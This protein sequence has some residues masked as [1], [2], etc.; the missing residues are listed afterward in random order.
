MET[1]HAAVSEAVKKLSAEALSEKKFLRAFEI[2]TGKQVYI[3]YLITF[4]VNVKL[5]QR[6]FSVNEFLFS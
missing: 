5:D 3:L 1:L 6:A 4:T 2:N